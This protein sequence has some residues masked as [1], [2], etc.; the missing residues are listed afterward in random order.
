MDKERLFRFLDQKYLSRCELANKLPLGMD[1]DEI[2]NTVLEGR[3]ARAVR[4]P[5]KNAKGDYYWYVLTNRMISASEVIVE[6]LMQHPAEQELHLSSVSTIEEIFF[7]SYMEGSQISIQE[8]MAFLQSGQEAQDI[9]ELM[10]LGN[11]QAGSFAARNIYHAI[12]EDYMHTLA[13]ILTNGLDNGGG[14]F[15]LTDSIEIPSMILYNKT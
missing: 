10:L 8:A 4:L 6:E 3:L 15:R 9:E 11:R 14:D 13:Y 7:T 2:W 5:L 12:D 1:P